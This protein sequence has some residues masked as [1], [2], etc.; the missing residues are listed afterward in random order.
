MRLRRIPFS[1]L[2]RD[3]RL[4]HNWLLLVSNQELIY[5]LYPVSNLKSLPSSTF[6]IRSVFVWNILN[7]LKPIT[8]SFLNKDLLIIGAHPEYSRA[9]NVSFLRFLS[10]KDQVDFWGQSIFWNQ[11][12]GSWSPFKKLNPSYSAFH[13]G[14]YTNRHSF[15]TSRILAKIC[16]LRHSI[17]VNRGQKVQAIFT[18]SKAHLVSDE[19][20]KPR[21]RINKAIYSNYVMSSGER[22]L[23]KGSNLIEINHSKSNGRNIIRRINV[24][25]LVFGFRFSK[26]LRMVNTEKKRYLCN[27]SFW[28]GLSPNTLHST[29]IADVPSNFKL[30]SYRMIN[31]VFDDEGK[32]VNQQSIYS[33]MSPIN[34]EPKGFSRFSKSVCLPIMSSLRILLQGDVYHLV[35]GKIRSNL[36]SIFSHSY[37]I[38]K[39]DFLFLFSRFSVKNSHV[40]NLK[41]DNY[42]ESENYHNRNITGHG[43]RVLFKL[44]NNKSKA[45]TYSMVTMLSSPVKNSYSFDEM[46]L[47]GSLG[48]TSFHSIHSSIL[49]SLLGRYANVYHGNRIDASDKVK[50]I[51]VTVFSKENFF[52]K[53][54]FSSSVVSTSFQLT[55]KGR[56]SDS[57]YQKNNLILKK[58]LSVNNRFKKK[59][60]SFQQ[61]A[62][63]FN[64][65]PSN[66]I[67]L[68]GI[69]H[70]LEDMRNS[71][72]DKTNVLDDTLNPDRVVEIL[73][74][75]IDQRFGRR[76]MTRLADLIYERMIQRLKIDRE[77]MG[78]R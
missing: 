67:S 52:S 56:Q 69:Q 5:L 23:G 18:S 25:F 16:P 59:L 57:I 75:K 45:K 36:H 40:K 30:S 42:L 14:L 60:V 58:E 9:L 47:T 78:I 20:T 48:N 54:N 13:E 44:E 64:S 28:R 6:V 21:L 61:T 65:I 53:K 73:F 37:L 7:H 33:L 35:K 46:T 19:S 55:V 74:K 43:H 15:N 50:T 70:N 11:V 66:Y 10:Q 41:N 3:L 38:S 34:E 68:P 32:Y 1:P 71:A 22:F 26:K 27:S 77:R 17:A 24:P 63:F 62:R 39:G 8:R 76:Q 2:I 31:S 51:P 49:G 12:F 29:M 72:Q 4:R